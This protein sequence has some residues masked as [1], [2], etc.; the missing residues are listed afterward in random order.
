M[1]VMWGAARP[2]RRA[3]DIDLPRRSDSEGNHGPR[4]NSS[5]SLKLEHRGKYTGLDLLRRCG[6]DAKT[7]DNAA[8]IAISGW[9][10][11]FDPRP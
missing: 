1:V 8:D 9:R 3:A 5:E 2:V 10:R 11:R 6:D 4:T 7:A